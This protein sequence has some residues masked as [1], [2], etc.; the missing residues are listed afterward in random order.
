MLHQLDEQVKAVAGEDETIY[1]A[2]NR[3]GAMVK[4]RP[5]QARRFQFLAPMD[6]SK[7]APYSSRLIPNEEGVIT[8]TIK[9][10]EDE[11][12]FVVRRQAEPVSGASSLWWNNAWSMQT[13]DDFDE[14]E[15]VQRPVQ[16]IGIV[17][18]EDRR[19]DGTDRRAAAR[20]YAV[21]KLDMH[22]GAY[23]D[24]DEGVDSTTE[25]EDGYLGDVSEA[26][27]E[28]TKQVSV[29]N[30]QYVSSGYVSA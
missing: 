17:Q 7:V 29:Q 25:G 11:D 30:S 21:N 24:D 8:S 27:K 26:T 1:T 3:G 28:T 18:V 6:T 15:Q 4:T 2:P 16:R 22:D 13:T 9:Q 12:D 20:M 10:T 5:P 19:N 23:S 14:I